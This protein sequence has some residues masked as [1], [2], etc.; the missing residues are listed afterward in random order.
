MDCAAYILLQLQKKYVSKSILVAHNARLTQCTALLVQICL[1]ISGLCLLIVVNSMATAAFW[2]DW[3]NCWS[4]VGLAHKNIQAKLLSS[5]ILTLA[6]N[7]SLLMHSIKSWNNTFT[8]VSI[9]CVPT[10]LL[11]CEREA[12]LL[13]TTWRIAPLQTSQY[14]LYG[15]Y[16]EQLE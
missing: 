4:H 14:S 2:V 3:I 11:F 5:L 16:M 12:I 9:Y 13:D 7:I 6:S 10:G 15:W 8:N 1:V